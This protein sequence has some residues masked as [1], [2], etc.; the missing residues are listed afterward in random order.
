MDGS[1]TSVY[2]QIR[3]LSEEEEAIRPARWCGFLT[4]MGA[5]S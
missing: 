2:T 5:P 1:P 4:R 3:K